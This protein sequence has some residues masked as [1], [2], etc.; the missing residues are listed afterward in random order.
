MFRI[1]IAALCLLGALFIVG[2]SS[3]ETAAGAS[4]TGGGTT[5]KPAEPAKPANAM[6]GDW[7]LVMDPE[8]MKAAPKDAKPPEMTIKFKDDNTFE[9][10]M[11]LEG[12]TSTA[13]GKYKLDGK[14]LTM[15][16]EMEDGKPSTTKD[17]TVSLAD[18]MKSFDVPGAAGMGKIVK[19]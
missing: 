6:V 9:A 16:T 15:D 13:T 2:C 4:T 14:T 12:K 8:A 3:S 5:G 11:L 1:K 7:K 19:Q 10:S 18:D 17:E